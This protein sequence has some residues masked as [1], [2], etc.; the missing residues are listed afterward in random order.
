MIDNPYGDYNT[1]VS[2]DAML[3]YPERFVHEDLLVGKHSA[4]LVCCCTAM[5]FVG[6]CR[7]CHTRS[8]DGIVKVQS[9][10]H[11]LS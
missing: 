2:E 4:S 8:T 7:Q 11:G 6:L 9:C 10:D 5:P 1:I 3:E